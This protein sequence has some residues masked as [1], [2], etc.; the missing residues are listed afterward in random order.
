MITIKTAGYA[1][2]T[3]DTA[4]KLGRARDGCFY[5]A[6]KRD[7]F[8]HAHRKL[9]GPFDTLKDALAFGETLPGAWSLYSQKVAA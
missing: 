6:E 5:V 4:T 1:Y 8:D 9:H 7:E 2:A 3:S